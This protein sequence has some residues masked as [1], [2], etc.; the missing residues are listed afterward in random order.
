M[1]VERTFAGWMR[2]SF[3]AIGIGLAF[4]ALFGELDPP[5]LARVI[6]TIFILLAAFLAITAER[7]ACRAVA[8]MK[9]HTVDA[10]D[11]PHLRYVAWAVAAGTLILAVSIWLMH[12]A[13][14]PSA[15][16]GG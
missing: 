3:A 14:L 16:P 2:T 7:R 5:W 12:N 1:T 9:A 11:A 8:R 4:E 15:L 13:E 6:A 10:P